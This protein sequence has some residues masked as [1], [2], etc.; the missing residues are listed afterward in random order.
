MLS[1]QDMLVGS[2][3]LRFVLVLVGVVAR[4]ERG[5][6]CARCRRSA[7]TRIGRACVLVMPMFVFACSGTGVFPRLRRSRALDIC[8]SLDRWHLHRDRVLAAQ[9]MLHA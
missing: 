7:G 9:E 1:L 2:T 4:E 5:T 8:F 6:R 3:R